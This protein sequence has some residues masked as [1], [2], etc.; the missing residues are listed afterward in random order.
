MQ[1]RVGSGQS[2]MSKPTGMSWAR[3][4]PSASSSKSGRGSG[5]KPQ[6][7]DGPGSQGVV[8]KVECFL[9]PQTGP[10]RKGL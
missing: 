2:S 5:V 9:L 1:K 4:R 7:G 6:G 3:P 8:K 10:Y